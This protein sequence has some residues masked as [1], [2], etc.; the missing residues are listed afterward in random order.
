MRA[1]RAEQGGFPGLPGDAHD[2]D[3]ILERPVGAALSGD[4]GDALL[5]GDQRGPQVA[6]DDADLWP[7]GDPVEVTTGRE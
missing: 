5:P 1:D 3:L 6:G 2:N 7:V 4:V